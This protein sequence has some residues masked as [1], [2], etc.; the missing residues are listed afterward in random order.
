MSDEKRLSRLPDT[1]L[2]VALFGIIATLNFLLFIE[3][4]GSN[5]LYR[6]IYGSLSFVLDGTEITLWLRGVRQRNA[7]FMS[8]ALAIACLGLFASTGA[9]LLIATADDAAVATA[10]AKGEAY[11]KS[12]ID[13]S[14]SVDAWRVRLAA[15]PPE[16]TSQLRIVATELDKANA[17][18]ATAKAEQRQAQLDA[19]L[20]SRSS[21]ALSRSPM[22][23]LLS[24]RLHTSATN[25]K[26]LFLLIVSVLLQA[27]ALIVTYHR[28]RGGLD[29]VKP[30]AKVATYVDSAAIRH[31]S[32]NGGGVLCGK[33]MRLMVAPQAATRY[34]LCDICAK[35]G[36]MA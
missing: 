20:S 29:N 6:I 15:V 33:P 24:Q 26:L 1:I 30:K 8:L 2:A 18:L 27:S 34:V 12:V 3:S 7:I 4:A 35:R 25:L 31:I 9:A 28:E 21:P 16:F 11:E 5:P 22:F 23:D 14:A 10:A 17:S 32:N 36:G 13:A 19:T